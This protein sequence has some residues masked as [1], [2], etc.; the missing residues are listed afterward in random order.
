[1]FDFGVAEKVVPDVEGTL[2][3]SV[4]FD[5]ADA[6]A[7]WKTLDNSDVK[8]SSWTWTATN[9]DGKPAVNIG[10]D[11]KSSICDYLISP[12][13]ELKEG[14]TYTITADYAAP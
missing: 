14:K 2:P 8:G 13:F 6:F 10:T 12:V 11:A 7:T 1:M 3:Y 4:T 5:S 9:Y